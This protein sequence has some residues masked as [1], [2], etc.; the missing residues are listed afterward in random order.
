MPSQPT[1]R[2]YK[3]ASSALRDRLLYALAVVTL[4]AAVCGCSRLPALSPEELESPDRIEHLAPNAAAELVAH[5]Q[6]LHDGAVNLRLDGLRTIPKA[7]A[8]VLASSL[9]DNACLCLDGVSTLSEDVAK[10][11]AS[12]RCHYL[13]LNRLEDLSDDVARALAKYRGG[14]YGS[15][16]HLDG[17]RTLSLDGIAHLATS[18][19][20]GLS[21]NGLSALTAEQ[22]RA[23]AMFQGQVLSL[24][25]VKSLSPEVASELA[26]YRGRMLSL[27]GLES[28]SADSAE[29]LAQFQGERLFLEGL[30]D[31]SDQV[32]NALRSSGASVVT[33]L[34]QL[35][36][37]S[38][39]ADSR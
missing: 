25:G 3:V 32:L 8:A 10:E 23:L 20:R 29:T 38:N 14:Q 34:G 35:G 19:A 28:I 1:S 7:S 21:L 11:I 12:T 30:K 36:E 37:P 22:A 6:D 27:S 16:L 5:I 26:G 15:D 18:S 9:P 17:A 31:P 13:S 24:D 39:A 33:P 2:S 4:V